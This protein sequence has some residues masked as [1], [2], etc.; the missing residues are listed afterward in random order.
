M[1][2]LNMPY[3]FLCVLEA[4]SRSVLLKVVTCSWNKNEVGSGNGY[5]IHTVICHGSL[6][7][8]REC[9][10]EGVGRGGNLCFLIW[11]IMIMSFSPWAMVIQ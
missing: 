3:F 6:C 7:I 11:E 4:L 10:S 8:S 5:N 9:G 2:R 1:F